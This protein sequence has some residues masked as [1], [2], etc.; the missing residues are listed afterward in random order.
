MNVSAI[1]DA[2]VGEGGFDTS[3]VDTTRA[4][5]LGWVQ[6]RYNGALS[7]SRWRKMAVPLGPTVAGQAQYALPAHVIDMRRLRVD[8]SRPWLRVTGED[9][10]DLQA[11]AAILR[12]NTGAFA[13]N[14]E[15]DADQVVELWPAPD[16][17]GLAIDA[18]CEVTDT[19]QLADSGAGAGSVPNLPDDLH[20]PILVKGAIAEGLTVIE[21]RPDLAAPFEGEA[22]AAIK[23]LTR[24]ARSRVG[25]G[26]WQARVNTTG[27]TW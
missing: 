13:P 15:A 26:P 21:K 2:V 11:G 17:S 8:G 9:L 5:I 18:L 22:A 12:G 27:A 25:S 14:F 6:T 24:R 10:W 23:E 4:V 1:I 3:A 7:A 19:T 16:K 20:R